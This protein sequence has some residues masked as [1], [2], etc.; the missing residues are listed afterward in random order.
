MSSY[1][2]SLQSVRARG[3]AVVRDR[4]R[5][6]DLG[7]KLIAL[8]DRVYVAVRAGEVV[9]TGQN[10]FIYRDGTPEGVSVEIG[11]EVAA[12]F[13]AAGDV[14]YSETPAGDAAMTTHTGPYAGLGAAH[15]AV[16]GWCNENGRVRAGVWWEVYGD[17]EEDPAKLRTEVCYAVLPEP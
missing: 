12:P 17:W 1:K 13:P 4:R 6:S 9:Q 3:V 15:E 7:G 8:L 16:I 11:V 10:V 14:Q 5:W 2:V